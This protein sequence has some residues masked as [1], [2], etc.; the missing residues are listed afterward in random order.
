MEHRPVSDIQFFITIEFDGYGVYPTTVLGVLNNLENALYQSDV[1]DIEYLC[2]ELRAVF[3]ELSMDLIRDASIHRLKEFDGRR[4]LFNNGAI[5][6]LQL[7]GTLC[8]SSI[9]V[10]LK[11]LDEASSRGYS[12]LNSSGGI[13]P[14]KPRERMLATEG[15]PMLFCELVREKVQNIS[16]VVRVFYSELGA[17]PIVEIEE[18]A[19]DCSETAM[20]HSKNP[21]PYKVNILLR[22]QQPDLILPV[23]KEVSGISKTT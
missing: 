4:I 6:K 12:Q 23:S 19:C 7:N 15:K 20:S 13:D 8:G 10:F 18:P 3:P 22:F 9:R 17:R 5:G 21:D 11:A 14:R 1:S 16:Q 2:R